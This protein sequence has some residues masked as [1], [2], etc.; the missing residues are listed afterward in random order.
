MTIT[1]VLILFLSVIFGAF[2]VEI[3]KPKKKKN[4][5]ILLTF[6]GAYLLA[7]SL[8]HL[9]PELFKYNTTKNIG[10]YIFAGF[11]L[12][13]F[14]K[15]C[16]H[17]IQHGH[18]NKK[19]IIP[20]S[21]LFSLCI[22]AIL[23]GIP[24]GG[25]LEKHTH[26]ALLYGV[27]LHKLPVSIVLMTFFMQVKIKKS[28]AY[29]LLLIFSCMGPA[30]V[31][32]GGLFDPIMLLQDEINAIVIGTFLHISTTILFE[33]TDNHQFNTKKIIILL[34]GALAAMLSI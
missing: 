28:K 1:T 31:Y 13:I 26:N 27:A 3:F 34:I 21:V 8:L 20:F 7:I 33:S 29:I 22:H 6:S 18:L 2:F 16:S 19:N 24:L 15:Y 32:L 25:G 11:V 9:L 4:I 30:G 23:E 12:Q 17:G 5:Q 14:L 10:L